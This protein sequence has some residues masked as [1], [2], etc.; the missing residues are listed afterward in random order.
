MF[1]RLF[2]F[3]ALCGLSGAA[4]AGSAKG[5]VFRVK[6]VNVTDGDTF[7]TDRLIFGRKTKIRIFGI[8]TPESDPKQAKCPAEVEAGKA[9]KAFAQSMADRA[10]GRATVTAVRDDAHN[11]RYVAKAFFTIE[12][13]RI[14]WGDQM[15]LAGHAV[16]YDP[17]KARDY[18]KPDWCAI[19][20]ERAAQAAIA[21]K[22]IDNLLDQV[23]PQ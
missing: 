7:L 4:V 11:N 9:A 20:A 8:D 12:G 1:R 3:I 21:A 5:K 19:L 14:E 16:Y 13:N 15:L 6:I 18:T 2:I 23:R 10:D 22:E 17:I